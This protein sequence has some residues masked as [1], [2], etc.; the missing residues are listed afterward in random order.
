[1]HSR[2]A[3][4]SA[5]DAVTHAFVR[6]RRNN[7]ANFIFIINET[8]LHL[9]RDFFFCWPD[10]L[11]ACAVVHPASFMHALNSRHFYVCCF[12]GSGFRLYV[13]GKIIV[14]LQQLFDLQK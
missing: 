11:F 4:F 14:V 10:R 2:C 8:N 12:Y 3:I 13:I 6:S 7:T 9:P 1:M 5:C